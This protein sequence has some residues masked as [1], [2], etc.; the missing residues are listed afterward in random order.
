MVLFLSF[1]FFFFWENSGCVFVMEKSQNNFYIKTFDYTFCLSV[2]HWCSINN[3]FVFCSVEE[4]QTEVI[5]TRRSFIK[6]R[7]IELFGVPRFLRLSCMFSWKTNNNQTI[8]SESVC[9]FF[10]SPQNSQDCA[11]ITPLCWVNRSLGGPF[12]GHQV[13]R[14]S[15][16]SYSPT[17]AWSLLASRHSEEQ[18]AGVPI[19]SK[20]T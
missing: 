5:L 14:P 7:K 3:W 16:V 19:D 15:N 17:S 6:S 10:Q 12:P 2:Y 11:T 1:N 9:T 4:K 8:S 13:I 20:A 18:L